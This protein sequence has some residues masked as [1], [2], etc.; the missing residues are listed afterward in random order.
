MS[1]LLITSDI[2]VSGRREH[3]TSF[4]TT[5]I[6]FL[7]TEKTDTHTHL[8]VQYWIHETLLIF[9]IDANREE[10]FIIFVLIKSTIKLCWE[11][12]MANLINQTCEDQKAVNI[13][14]IMREKDSVID[15]KKKRHELLI[16]LS[17][18]VSLLGRTWW[19]LCFHSLSTF[20][21]SK[22]ESLQYCDLRHPSFCRLPG[23]LV[24]CEAVGLSYRGHVMMI[25]RDSHK[26]YDF[27]KQR[28]WYPT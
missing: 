23:S 15:K 5:T 19:I 2:L 17:E 4:P 12:V 25:V 7:F 24:V 3:P 14:G 9:V 21:S 18:T 20:Q 22:Q 1:K 26:H 6:V 27:T 11:N 16:E 10:Y 28:A 13:L 8:Q